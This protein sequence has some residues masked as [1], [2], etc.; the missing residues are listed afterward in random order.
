[1]PPVEHAE[2]FRTFRKYSIR[3]ADINGYDRHPYVDGEHRGAVLHIAENTVRT[4]CSL[5]MDDNAPARLQLFLKRR[6]GFHIDAAAI[7]GHHARNADQLFA[8]RI[9]AEQLF[10]CHTA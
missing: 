6:H 4:S 8:E 7:H 9:F 2:P 10:F 1:M 3:A 5:G